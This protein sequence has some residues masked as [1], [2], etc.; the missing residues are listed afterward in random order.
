MTIPRFAIRV[1]FAGTRNYY[2]GGVLFQRQYS[3]SVVQHLFT[4]EETKGGNV[5]ME[6]QAIHGTSSGVTISGDSGGGEVE[7]GEKTRREAGDQENRNF[8]STTAGAA[9]GTSTAAPSPPNCPIAR[10]AALLE[11]LDNAETKVAEILEVAAETLDELAKGAVASSALNRE[12]V[13]ASNKNFLKLV[14]EVHGCLAPKAEW[15]RDYKP[16]PRSTYGERKE[17]ELLHEKA[18]FLRFELASMEDNEGRVGGNIAV[19]DAAAAAE[20]VADVPQ[21]AEKRA[22]EL[23]AVTAAARR[24]ENSAGER[25]IEEIVTASMDLG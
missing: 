13:D 11:E 3:R 21:R 12:K 10:N 19:S 9:A 5:M 15:I 16:Y 8:K 2:C 22:Q 25:A 14:S 23:Q 6:I 4:M 17:L 18:N 20:G 7:A 24:L 1:V